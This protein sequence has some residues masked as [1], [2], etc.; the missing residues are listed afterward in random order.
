M[1]LISST[2]GKVLHV[3][4]IELMTEEYKL[5]KKEVAGKELVKGVLH[6][7]GQLLKTAFPEKVSVQGQPL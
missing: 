2:T 4:H 5:L 6:F 3:E 7:T 1:I